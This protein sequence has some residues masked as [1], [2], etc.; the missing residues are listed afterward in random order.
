MVVALLFAVNDLSAQRVLERRTVTE[1][2]Q[3]EEMHIRFRV[4][5]DIIDPGYMNNADSLK[6]IVEW[7]NEVRND[8]M[9][10]IVSVEF[11][12]AVS[13]EG[14]VKF[15]RWLSN[16]RLTALERYVRKRIDIPEEIIVRND[17]YIAWNELRDMVEASNLHNKAEI[18]AIIDEGNSSK[19]E[20][21]DSRIGKLK[22]LDNGRTW[23]KIFDEHFI[24]MRNAYTIL[25]TKH[26]QLAIEYMNQSQPVDVQPRT[27]AAPA[28][29]SP[30]EQAVADVLPSGIKKPETRY[31]YVKTNIV[32]LA[33][34][35]GN[36]GVEFDLGRYLS[37]YLP[38]SYTALDY[39]TS[40]TKFRTFA[41]QPEL[42]VWPLKNNDKL[43][44][45]AHLGF[46]YYNY[47]FNGDYRYQDHRGKT[48]T[49]GGGLSL[50]YRLPISR[51]KNWK[52][53]FALGVGVY[54]LKYDLFINEYNGPLFD[55]RKKT[56]IGLDN[57][58]VGVSYRIPVKTV[59]PK[60]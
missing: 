38:I 19:G 21:L 55:T 59:L 20:V 46:A 39:F 16:A 26:S 25:V 51:D 52:L 54:P 43:F 40:T 45:G 11:C 14:S 49:L 4:A 31:M 33:L 22:R 9:V 3:R 12:G 17:H 34:L 48:P 36:A 50:G 24:H 18:L 37:F 30:S 27:F 44:I 35:Q 58:L 53:E 2:L 60:K 7:I 41:L 42:R 32:G 47:A 29:A 57:V 1:S 8:S 10:D 56:Y 23:R 6:R 15:N 28:M 13:P 5:K